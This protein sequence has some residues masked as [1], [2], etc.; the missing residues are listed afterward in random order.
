MWF[1]WRPSPGSVVLFLIGWGCGWLLFWRP[2]PL[3]AGPATRRAVA[4]VVP[5]RDEAGT[6]PALLPS[7][8]RELR[9]G[10]ELVVVDDHSSDGTASVAARL[11]ARVVSA[12]DLPPGWTGKCWACHRGALATSSPVLV[13]LDADVVLEAPDVLDRLVGRLDAA[14]TPD[15]RLVTVQPWHR[16]ARATE[17]LSLLFNITAVMGSAAFTPLGERP[18]VAVAFG[19]MLACTRS[20]YEAIGGHAHPSVRGA[21][22]E[23]LALADHFADVRAF[24]GRPSVSF[25][26]YPR[27]VRQLV[28]GWTKN[29]A[30]GAG[31]IRWWF[32]L[33]VV[34]WIWSLAG[35]WLTSPWFYGAS[36]VQL[37]VLGRRSGRFGLPAALVFPALTVFFLVVFVRSVV[38][39]ALG[40]SVTWKQR[41][42]PTRR[43]R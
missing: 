24:T 16:T 5:A 34:G 25:R 6:L 20:G 37:V 36:V 31:H 30:T 4:V 3:P 33:A 14:S 19:P 2:R 42:V 7:V 26:M 15:E 21:V 17:Q 41:R 12:P 13:F 27:G 29:I 40:G 1:D 9:P 38:L 10:D 23:D 18:R 35:G 8:V 39:T 22:A 43:R 11:G 32:A 28:A